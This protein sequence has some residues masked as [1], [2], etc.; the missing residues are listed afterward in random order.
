MKFTKK[1][2]HCGRVLPL[3]HF[4]KHS[5]TYDGFDYWCKECVNEAKKS[6]TDMVID[7]TKEQWKD[8]KDFEGLYQVSDM[9]RVR[10]L[11][12][13][14]GSQNRFCKGQIIRPDMSGG[15]HYYYVGLCHKSGKRVY[16]VVHRIV[17][18]AFLPNP[19]NKPQVDHIDGNPYNNKS[20]NLRWVTASE[21]QKNPISQRRKSNA[22]K[23]HS[24]PK[25]GESSRARKVKGVN[26]ATGENVYF[27]C[28]TSAA[29][30]VNKKD[31]GHITQCC[32]GK[33]DTAYGYKWE[34]ID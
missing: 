22:L 14:M 27:D 25:L 24:A 1:C 12:R 18:E 7:E 13:R 15:A 2:S 10:S 29:N 26:I 16:K 20:S 4:N 32:Q 3:D 30:Y 9:G 8:I 31:T 28:L 34:Y 17:A 19:L 6:T 5:N 33:R 21:N 23:G 11:D